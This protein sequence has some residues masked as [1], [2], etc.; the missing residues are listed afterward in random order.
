MPY[1][2]FWSTGSVE[3]VEQLLQ[4][5]TLYANLLLDNRARVLMFM[6]KLVKPY[7]FCCTIIA[8][9]FKSI[10]A[11]RLTGSNFG[12]VVLQKSSFEKLA[13]TVLFSKVPGEYNQSNGVETMNQ[14]HVTFNN[15]L[16]HASYDCTRGGKRLENIVVTKKLELII[17]SHR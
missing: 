9:L 3:D 16:L 11:H 10:T 14:L 12:C 5:L 4:S 15:I 1:K 7:K 13:E 17:Q 2:S 6:H 8:Q